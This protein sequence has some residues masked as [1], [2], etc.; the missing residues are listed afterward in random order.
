VP[1]LQADMMKTLTDYYRAMISVTAEPISA[2]DYLNQQ[3]ERSWS[4]EYRNLRWFGLQDGM[5][6]LDLGCGPGDFTDRLARELPRCRITAVDAE[7][8]SVE[9]ARRRLA[10]RAV[11]VKVRAE[12]T[13][14][15]S[16]SFDF[17]LARLL[18]QHL[19]EPL[20]VA[21]E[22]YRLLAPGGKLVITDVD[23]ELFGIVEPRIPGLRFLLQRYGSSQKSCGGNRRIGRQLVGLLHSA[24]FIEPDIEALATHSDRAGMAACL[25]QFDAMPLRSLIETGHLSRIEYK[26]LRC[27]HAWHRRQ[28]DQF[29]LVLGFMA[30]G[31]KPK[32]NW[33]T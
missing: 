15:P 19:R 11:V 2:P 8:R 24:G 12:E 3:V 26:M 20:Q 31:V 1:R 21:K 23:D 4:K 10:D 16:D 32:T 17:V 22:A 13:G 28:P 7:Y 14:L 33:E 29:A 25:P 18:F 27:A 30:C 9:H 5:S 6:V